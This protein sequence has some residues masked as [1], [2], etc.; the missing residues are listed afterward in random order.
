MA[1]NL[2]TGI[3]WLICVILIAFNERE[4][5]LITCRATEIENSM[6]KLMCSAKFT[7]N[8]LLTYHAVKDVGP[9][10]KLFL[11][12]SADGLLQL[13][14][15]FRQVLTS[16][17]PSEHR[18]LSVGVGGSILIKNLWIKD[19][20]NSMPRKCLNYPE[21]LSAAK[22]ATTDSWNLFHLIGCRSANCGW[23]TVRCNSAQNICIKHCCD[24]RLFVS[25]T[26]FLCK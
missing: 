26:F 3:K 5:N 9:M 23:K 6:H 22:K 25:E 21:F 7:L 10:V 19:G 2:S 11:C 16:K 14:R 24:C 20:Q 13:V 4:C 12:H 18:N 8:E 15:H 1:T 17:K